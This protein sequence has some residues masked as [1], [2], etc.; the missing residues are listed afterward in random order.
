MAA[1]MTPSGAWVFVEPSASSNTRSN[2]P[3]QGT[4]PMTTDVNI[5]MGYRTAR[6]LSQRQERA[7]RVRD[8]DRNVVWT[9]THHGDDEGLQ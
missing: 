9:E 2:S 3:S 7:S 4:H 1:D 8:A 6:T 5:D